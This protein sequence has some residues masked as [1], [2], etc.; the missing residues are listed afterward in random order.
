METL[1]DWVPLEAFNE[2]VLMRK[3]IRKP[4]TP[5]AVE[6]AVKTLDRLR[7]EGNDPKEV[8]EQSI[9]NSWQGLFEL[10]TKGIVKPFKGVK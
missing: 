1:P 7:K 8:L 5:Y 2:F 10:K 9:F 3:K 6:L 4:L